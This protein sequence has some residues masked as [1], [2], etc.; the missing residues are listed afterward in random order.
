MRSFMKIKS[1]RNRETTHLI[2]DTGKSCPSCKFLTSPVCLLT[3]FAKI[4]FSRKFPDLGYT[5]LPNFI[6]FNRIC[7]ITVKSISRV[8][9]SVDPDQMASEKSADLDLHC[10]K[11]GFIFLDICSPAKFC[12]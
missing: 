10:L 1:S 7:N 9:N 12:S 4:K 5:L 2:T 3:L 6:P 11:T 8:E